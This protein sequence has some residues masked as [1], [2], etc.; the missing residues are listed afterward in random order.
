MVP[1][2]RFWKTEPKM[3]CGCSIDFSMVSRPNRVL[4]PLKGPRKRTFRLL[5]LYAPQTRILEGATSF[6]TCVSTRFGL[7]TMEKSIEQAHHIITGSHS[8]T[9]I[10]RMRS[11]CNH[12]SKI[13]QHHRTI[14]R[15]HA[16]MRRMRSVCN[17]HSQILQHH[18][19]ITT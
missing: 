8:H 9:P 14:T 12:H 1:K 13:L 5:S 3:K 19:I 11:V 2:R 7:Q 15:S 18:R 16:H 17:H 6:S 10:R 4:T